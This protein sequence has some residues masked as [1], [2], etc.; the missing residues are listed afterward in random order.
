VVQKSRIDEIYV[1]L[2]EALVVDDGLCKRK[3]VLYFCFIAIFC[4]SCGPFY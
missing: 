1:S 2:N 3:F 4:T